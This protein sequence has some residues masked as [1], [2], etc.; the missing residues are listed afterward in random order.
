MQEGKKCIADGPIETR[1]NL[2]G[3][4]T[5]Y[6]RAHPKDRLKTLAEAIDKLIEIAGKVDYYKDR[7]EVLEGEIN[8][9]E[10]KHKKNIGKILT[11]SISNIN[12]STK[13]Q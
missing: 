7:I 1:D 9:L 3:F 8:G 12:N 2:H 13:K 4:K 6:N 5:T 11:R 10:D